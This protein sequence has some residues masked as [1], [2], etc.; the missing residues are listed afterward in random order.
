MLTYSGTVTL[1][2]RCLT[3]LFPARDAG[4]DAPAI[5]VLRSAADV[6]LGLRFSSL[7]MTLRIDDSTVRLERD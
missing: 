6:P 1:P 7:D 5:D 2:W 3:V 4:A